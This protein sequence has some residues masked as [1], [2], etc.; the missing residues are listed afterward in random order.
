MKTPYPI[1]TYRL[2]L[3]STFRFQETSEIIEYVKS[4]GVSHFYTS[5]FLQA[6]KDSTHGYDIINPGQINQQIGTQEEF[7]ALCQNGLGILLDIVPNHMAL[8]GNL[9]W[10]DILKNGQ[11]S[12]YASYFDINWEHP[13]EHH[14]APKPNDLGY[15]RFFDISSLVGVR[16][17]DE[18]VFHTVLKLPLEWYNNGLIQGFRVDHPD[19]MRNP[20]EFFDRLRAACPDAWIVAEKILEPGETLP[21]DWP[22]DGTT[23]Y[24]FIHLLNHLFLYPEGK[25]HLTRAYESFTGIHEDFSDIVYQSK[26]DVIQTLFQSEMHWLTEIL[27]KYTKKKLKEYLSTTAACFP[28]YRA[29]DEAIIASAVESAKKRRPDLD[30]S[31]FDFFKSILTSDN[32]LAIRFQQFTGPVMA[33]GFEDTALYRYNRLISLNEVGGDPAQFGLSLAAFHDACIKSKPFS[34]LASSTHDTKH[35]EDFR[36]RLNL[37][38]EIPL[39]FQ[40]WAAMNEKHNPPDRNTEYLFYQILIGAWPIELPRILQYLEKA[41]REAKQHTSWRAINADYETKVATFARNVLSDKAFI[42]VLENFVEKLRQP[43][44]VTGLSATLIKLTAPGIPD[45]YQGSELWNFSL[46]DPDNRRPVDFQKRKHLLEELNLDKMDEGVPKL[47]IIQKV[48]SFRKTN[49]ETFTIGSYLPLYANGS[50]KEHI[51]AFIRNDSAITIVPRFL[52]KLA[53]DWEDTTIT[54]PKGKWKNLFTG[55]K[56]EGT[57]SIKQLLSKFPVAFL[58]C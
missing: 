41:T 9:W 22:V 14:G 8:A 51:V 31:L 58:S 52:I 26:L 43:G 42:S 38:A 19:G 40:E 24:E 55:D 18:K 53:N 29:F 28:V 15:R 56:L 17:E 54:L 33:K 11:L 34:L 4:L 37:L 23:G 32:D 47:F 45:I 1:A 36:A 48:L 3:N 16:I 46:V 13:W 7:K 10:A 21:P 39:D 27:K 5:P 30:P 6:V 49:P 12:P 50:K 35:S 20:K 44:Y 25:D 2:Q 57:I